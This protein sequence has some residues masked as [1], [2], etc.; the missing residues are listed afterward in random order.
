MAEINKAFLKIQITW[1]LFFPSVIH[2]PKSSVVMPACHKSVCGRVKP[3]SKSASC[4]GSMMPNNGFD[5][6][7]LITQLTLV[8]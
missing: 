3:L 4:L 7:F 6:F 1:F 2:V 8:T 5:Y